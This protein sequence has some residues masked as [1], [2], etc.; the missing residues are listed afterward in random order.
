MAGCVTTCRRTSTTVER[1]CDWNLIKS[2]EREIQHE[3]QGGQHDVVQRFTVKDSMNEGA[4]KGTAAMFCFMMSF[5]GGTVVQVIQ[6]SYIMWCLKKKKKLCQFLNGK[7]TSESSVIFT[8]GRR[9]AS[10]LK[11]LRADFSYHC[12]HMCP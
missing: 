5:H 6:S 2:D 12:P 10:G 11:A 8:V 7:R 9:K 1:C 4:M 3:T